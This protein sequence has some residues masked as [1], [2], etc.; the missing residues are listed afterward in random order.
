MCWCCV[1]SV[2]GDEGCW[3]FLGGL[4]LFA[5]KSFFIF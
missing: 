4:R 3:A 2:V 1:G 5:S